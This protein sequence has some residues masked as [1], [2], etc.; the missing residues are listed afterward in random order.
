MK[1]FLTRAVA[2]L[3]V[4]GA[5]MAQGH[6]VSAQAGGS[7]PAAGAQGESPELAE[8]DR[9][10]AEVVK[11]Y[12]AGRY[13]EALPLAQQVVGVR[14]KGLGRTH[15][16]VAVSLLNLGA[17]Q[18]KLARYEEARK[19]YR[20]SLAIYEEDAAANA[21]QVAQVLDSLAFI[22]RDIGRAIELHERS[23]ELKAKAA[24]AES[25][26]AAATLY[27]LGHLYELRG[28]L[29]KAAHSFRRFVAVGE[30]VKLGNASD[31]GAAHFRLSC[32]S[33]KK[34]EEAEAQKHEARGRESFAEIP[35]GASLVDAGVVN[36]KAISKPQPSY[37]E[38]AK[39]QRAQG[40]VVVKILVG[41]SGGVLA[42]CA[43]TGPALLRRAS[44][45]AA[46]GARFTETTVGG[47]PVKVTGLITYRFVLQ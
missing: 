15:K 16:L 27:P 17:V 9:L 18:Q 10:S 31:V 2:V 25:R 40:E 41:E 30:K 26:D 28:E 7:K 4:C 14:E 39:R 13:E 42:A 5:S 12:Q 29:D 36:G 33:R 21:R 6:V 8:A 34:G 20:R 32:L 11:L 46:Y 45:V 23:R 44:E 24:G 1:Y 19:A 35:E 43:E 37:P 38:E 47:K 3:V 22:E